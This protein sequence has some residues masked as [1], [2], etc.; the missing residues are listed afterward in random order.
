M[1]NVAWGGYPDADFLN[2]LAPELAT[3]RNTL[4]EKCGNIGETAGNLNSDWAARLGL[5]EGIPIALGAFDAHLGGRATRHSRSMW[6]RSR[7]SSARLL[8]S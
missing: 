4:P 7:V 1:F 5:P 3:V 2:E 6:H 8:W